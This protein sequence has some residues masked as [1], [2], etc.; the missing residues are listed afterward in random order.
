MRNNSSA[1]TLADR[2][3]GEIK[4]LSAGAKLPSQRDLVNRFGASATTVA[5][6][7]ALLSQQGL[8]E[9]RPGSGTFRTSSNES[10]ACRDTSWQEAALEITENIAGGPQRRYASRSLANTLTQSGPDVVDLNGGYLHPNLQ[11]LKLLSAG[12]AR[13]ARRTEAWDR[14]AAGGVPQLRDW[15]SAEIGGGLS[16]H[17]IVLSGGGQ[18]ALATIIRAL[19]QPGDPVIIESPTYPGIIAAGHA[20]GLRLVPVPLDEH[21]VQPDLLDE[22]LTRSGARV[23]VLQPLFQNPTGATMTTARQAEILMIARR[24]RAFV[25]EDDFARYM[26]HRDGTPLPPP[27]ITNDPHGTVVHIRS[28]T[29][30]TS[31]NLRVAG[32]AARGPVMARLRAAFVIDT[33]TVPAPLQLTA[34]EIVTGPG[35]RRALSTLGAELARRRDASVRAI[36]TELSSQTLAITP[37]G[38]YHL[39]VTLPPH[40]D[41]DHV[42]E[43]ALSAGVSVTPGANYYAT[44]PTLP[45]L[46]ISYVATPSSADAITGIQRFARSR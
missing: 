26:A 28:L 29:K 41:A 20:A 27:L 17:D 33:M 25:I 38:G 45:H 42:C 19:G 30:V 37:R 24:H 1:H 23:I 5:H 34:L 46:R 22:A 11:P 6:A 7:L 39:W 43:I 18:S 36:T 15:F 3:A 14:P 8:V 12:L 31:P 35:W 2:L 32:V 40:E 10:T 4:D 13:A 44:G 16:R 21:G 9:S